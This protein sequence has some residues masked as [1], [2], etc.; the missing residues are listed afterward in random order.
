MYTWSALIDGHIHPPPPTHTRLFIFN[1]LIV[2]QEEGVAVSTFL[3][4]NVGNAHFVLISSASLSSGY[5]PFLKI[6]Q[7]MQLVYT[8]GI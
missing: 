3:C 5:Y 8:S 6:Y 2:A 7:A 1:Q 4:L